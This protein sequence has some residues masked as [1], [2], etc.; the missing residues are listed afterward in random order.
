MHVTPEQIIESCA[1]FS[2]Y[3]GNVTWNEDL[4]WSQDTI[5]NSIEDE[6][7]KNHVCSCLEGYEAQHCVGPLA[8]YFTLVELAFCNTKTMDSLLAALAKV[9]LNSLTNNSTAKHACIWQQMMTFLHVYNKVP[10]NATLLIL[11]QYTKCSVA[12]FC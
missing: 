6:V 5:Y 11:K 1:L 3:S 8:L 10:V 4:I 9:D 7:L 2:L 12:A